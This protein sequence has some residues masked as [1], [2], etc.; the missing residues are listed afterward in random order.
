LSATFSPESPVPSTPG[1][2]PPPTPFSTEY[3]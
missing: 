3:L 1:S 2:S